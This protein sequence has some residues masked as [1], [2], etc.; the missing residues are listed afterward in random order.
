MR[1]LSNLLGAVS[2]IMLNG[3]DYFEPLPFKSQS[4]L[5][6]KRKKTGAIKLRKAMQKRRNRR[7]HK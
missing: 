7:R 2:H 6:L 1:K 5:P 3:T 4:S